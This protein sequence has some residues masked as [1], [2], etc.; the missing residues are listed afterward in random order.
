MEATAHADCLAVALAHAVL[1]GL[2][3]WGPSSQLLLRHVRHA[4]LLRQGLLVG[5]VAIIVLA[6]SPWMFH[7]SERWCTV[8]AVAAITMS[9]ILLLGG[10]FTVIT[11]RIRA[12]AAPVPK[13]VLTVGAHPD[14]L[15]LAC[16]GTLAKL[17]DMGHD[18]HAL[19]LSRG[20]VGGAAAVRC[21]EAR[22]GARRLG[23]GDVLVHDFPDTHLALTSRE[24]TLAIENHIRSIDP[25]LIITHSAHDY[26]QDH[27]AV[28]QAVLR[29]ARRHH[30][31]LCFESPSV[32]S[33]FKP[34]VFFDVTDYMVVKQHAVQ[35]HQDQLRG[36][37]T[38]M[39]Q[40][41]LEG[42]AMFRGGQVRRERAEA[43]EVVRL[44]ADQ[45]GLV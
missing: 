6:L 43:F 19:V 15:E 10:L 12:E 1:F 16:G 8:V 20:G 5:S 40:Q 45:A 18:V 31:I 29:A 44:L 9:S 39:Q 30:S 34:T 28:H 11:C 38:Y 3:A 37:R 36:K 42:M 26:H 14:D 4:R 25:H 21:A 27:L 23:V 17:V 13:R 35:A 24:M 22:D 2:L 32:T 33:E 41:H 7:L